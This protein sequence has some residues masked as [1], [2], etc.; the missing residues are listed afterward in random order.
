M[1][2][3]DSQYLSALPCLGADHQLTSE[4]LQCKHLTGQGEVNPKFADLTSAPKDQQPFSRQTTFSNT[5]FYSHREKEESE[6]TEK[7]KKKIKIRGNI[8]NETDAAL[9]ITEKLT[10][11]LRCSLLGSF[12]LG[13]DKAGAEGFSFC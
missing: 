2:H 3:S 4:V 1:T 11:A 7:E 6:V 13:L 10:S 12:I 5:I 8:V 9:S